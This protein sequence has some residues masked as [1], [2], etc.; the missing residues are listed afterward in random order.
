MLTGGLWLPVCYSSW[1]TYWS[2]EICHLTGQG[3]VISTSS[4]QQET[5]I[6]YLNARNESSRFHSGLL[7]TSITCLNNQVVKISCEEKTCGQRLIDSTIPFIIGG[8]LAT[9]AAWPWMGTLNYAGSFV[10]GVV[11]IDTWHALSAAHCFFSQGDGISKA[12][13]PHY[14]TIQLGSNKLYDPNP[15]YVQIKHVSS[16]ILHENYSDSSA[17]HYND[18]AV[19]RLTTPVE[20]SD[21]VNTMCLPDDLDKDVSV[22][23][24]CYMAGWGITYRD[25]REY[26]HFTI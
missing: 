18:I 14:H 13:L 20:I 26:T 19:I 11:L 17:H 16:I 22:T 9:A 7:S 10:C 8:D 3:N 23:D 12:T 1:Q 5:A 6:I 2:K 25:R 4:V 21:Y 15:S 24:V